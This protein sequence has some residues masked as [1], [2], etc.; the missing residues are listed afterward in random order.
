METLLA[1]AR[2]AS[3]HSDVSQ[4]TCESRGSLWTR[5]CHVGY[6]VLRLATVETVLEAGHTAIRNF[7]I[8]ANTLIHILLAKI[9]Y[10][11]IISQSCQLLQ[12][13]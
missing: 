11:P 5:D 1:L 6:D 13:T 8:T 9:R 7:L 10:L 2:L 4:C 12:S 3:K